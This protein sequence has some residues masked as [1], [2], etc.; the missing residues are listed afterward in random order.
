MERI[1]RNYYNRSI[2]AIVVLS[3]LTCAAQTSSPT[4]TAK[5]PD[6]ARV[7]AE[8][9]CSFITGKMMSALPMVP[10]NCVVKGGGPLQ[11][12]LG[13][14]S[15]TDVLEGKMRRPWAT[16]LFL[17]AQALFF[18]GAVNGTCESSDK[19][20]DWA[21]CQLDIS[22]SHLSQQ[23]FYYGLRLDE[24]WR[25][26]MQRLPDPSSDVWYMGW[27]KVLVGSGDV[28]N[29]HLKSK[30]NAQLRVQNA[31]ANYLRA[32]PDFRLLQLRVTCSALS[33][34][35]SSVYVVVD[36]PD[37]L[38][39]GTVN[40]VMPLLETFGREFANSGYD[41]AVVFRSQWS[42]GPSPV[43][44]YN[45]YPLRS[46]AFW[47]EEADSGDRERHTTALLLTEERE[48]GQTD[49]DVF[50]SSPE[51]TNSL[52][53]RTAAILRIIPEA[54]GRSSMQLTD[55]SE[56]SITKDSQSQCNL[57]EGIEVSILSIPGG[58][59]PSVIG[60]APGKHRCRLDAF[61]VKGW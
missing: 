26:I 57:D 32:N 18:G 60:S 39:A 46:I 36:F 48:R 47:S 10:T 30:G 61:F 14:F 50:S 31:C 33:V 7:S 6:H 45:I 49:R 53:L 37:L 43:R 28:S 2:I 41:G 22:D 27:W 20:K 44:A 13:V 19:Q 5:K 24:G 29:P 11:Y 52:H 12:E 21:G 56:W 59:H 3:G 38:S 55:G 51:A 40:Y 16:T 9:V 1:E 54:K 4:P 15:P 58:A 8:A 35:D 17:T 42:T 34:G 23:S 25:E